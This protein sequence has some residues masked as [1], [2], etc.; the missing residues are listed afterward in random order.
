MPVSSP[1][2]FSPPAYAI[3]VPTVA[4]EVLTTQGG[5]LPPR[6]APASGGGIGAY[7]APAALLATQNDYDP[8]SGFPTGIGRLDL[9]PAAGGSTITGL[10]AGSDAQML[11]V[12]NLS[13]VDV[14]TLVNQS[15]SS[16]A[17]NR[18]R[19]AGDISIVPGETIVLCYYAGTINRWVIA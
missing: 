15:A 3:P 19:Y 13:G 8:G 4:G 6:F 14:I 17:P 12:G 10:L 9:T 11:L 18:F 5:K 2:T 1:P 7:L 16:A